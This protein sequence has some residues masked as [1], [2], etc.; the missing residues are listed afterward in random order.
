MQKP[1]TWNNK[2]A[3]P[4]QLEESTTTAVLKHRGQ[5]STSSM[6]N[7]QLISYQNAKVWNDIDRHENSD[8]GKAWKFQW[9]KRIRYKRAMLNHRSTI[10]IPKKKNPEEKNF[11]C[12]SRRKQRALARMEMQL[13]NSNPKR[14]VRRIKDEASNIE[15]WCA[16]RKHYLLRWQKPPTLMIAFERLQVHNHE[17]TDDDRPSPLDCISQPMNPVIVTP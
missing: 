10:A 17:Q 15:P 12:C 11:L 16:K 14:H 2:E 3:L 4:S 6:F 8:F 5:L 7:P 1:S 13:S 9:N